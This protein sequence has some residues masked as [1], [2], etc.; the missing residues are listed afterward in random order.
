MPPAPGSPGLPFANLQQSPVHQVQ[1]Q[2]AAQGSSGPAAHWPNQPWDNTGYPQF[3]KWLASD[4][5]FVVMRRLGQLHARVLLSKQ[6]RIV[7]L[8]ARL[9]F[10][11]KEEIIS[12][13]QNNGSFRLDAM[14]NKERSWILE[15]AERELEGY[16]QSTLH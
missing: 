4:E 11:D 10:L 6:D 8:E 2:T 13:D 7:Q 14:R 15:K 12:G 1:P 16:G 3:T 9:N 5:D